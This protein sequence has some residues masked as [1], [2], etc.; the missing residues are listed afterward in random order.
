MKLLTI[1]HPE[2]STQITLHQMEY[3]PI[4][5]LPLALAPLLSCQLGNLTGERERERSRWGSNAKLNAATFWPKA[6]LQANRLNPPQPHS[7]AC[8]IFS[9]CRPLTHLSQLRADSVVLLHSSGVEP[10][11]AAG[12]H[13][14]ERHLLWRWAMV[15]LVH[16]R[17]HHTA[18]VGHESHNCISI[19]HCR[20][21]DL[22]RT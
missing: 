5:P 14:V 11:G 16:K 15:G 17:Q 2:S 1:F 13:F 22:P 20:E 8:W 18:N 9:L 7:T 12:I 6:L 21:I 3:G 4:L 10:D 19:K